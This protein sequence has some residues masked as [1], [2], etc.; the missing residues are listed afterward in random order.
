MDKMTHAKVNLNNF[1]MG[2]S[3]AFDKSFE[4][5][6]YKLAFNSQRVTYIALRL[7]SYINFEEKYLADVAALGLIYK[8]NL[9]KEQ[10]SQIPLLDKSI[11]ED[12]V[13]KEILEL[14][15]LIEEH[16]CIQ[17]G[18]VT[19]ITE[20]KKMI[21]ASSF[22][23]DIK[24]NFEDLS[25]DMTF[26]FDLTNLLSLPTLIYN[27]L[28][29]YTQEME[30]KVLIDFTTLIHSLINK[31]IQLS[32]S[33]DIAIKCKQMCSL[34]N[35]DNKDLSRMMIAVNLYSLGKL[36]V[37]KDIYLKNTPL[38]DEEKVMISSIPYHSQATL[39]LIYGFDDIAKLCSLF[40]EKMDGSGKPYEMDGS[41]LSLKDRLIAI[42]I[43]Y[44][45]LLEP[46]SYRKAYTHDEA[47]NI[48]KQ[49]AQQGKLDSAIVE[50]VTKTFKG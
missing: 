19:N 27:F 28:Q 25:E 30:Y 29:D 44:Q 46:R 34:Y 4:L 31:Q 20:I 2:V 38:T 39:S 13:T 7:V 35:M 32:S 42:L 8:L 23:S 40:N 49:E 18:I 36:F 48:L 22:S 1:L 11:L 14:S 50:D 45:S 10:L 41:S 15:L 12:S 24:E 9:T 6:K 26:W 3:V 43:I 5:N 37:S 17:S 33:N 47:I 16:L 21:F